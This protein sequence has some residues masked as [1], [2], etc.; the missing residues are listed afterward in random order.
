M[1]CVAGRCSHKICWGCSARTEE[2]IRA[3]YAEDGSENSAEMEEATNEDT[4]EDSIIFSDN[5]DD[6]DVVE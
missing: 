4:S 3:M 6:D 5:V 2:N 1:I